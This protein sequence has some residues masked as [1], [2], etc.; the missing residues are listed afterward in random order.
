M[1]CFNWQCC[2][3]DRKDNVNGIGRS[4]RPTAEDLKVLLAITAL[5]AA[6][7]GIPDSPH[8]LFFWKGSFAN[9]K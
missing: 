1:L 3:V 9:T 8:F 6:F 4:N 2:P 7:A 5:A